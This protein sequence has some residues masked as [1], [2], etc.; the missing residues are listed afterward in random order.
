MAASV[1]H[2]SAPSD[3]GPR[4]SQLGTFLRYAACVT[5]GGTAPAMQCAH[6]REQSGSCLP[7][8]ARRW[9]RS[10]PPWSWVPMVVAAR[11]RGFS[12]PCGS[13]VASLGPMFWGNLSHFFLWLGSARCAPS[14]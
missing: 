4:N 12:A 9:P 2:T 3:Q 13:C 10:D 11:V 14:P 1:S 5:N 7:A 6:A 8:S